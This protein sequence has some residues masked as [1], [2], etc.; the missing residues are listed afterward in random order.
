MKA[1]LRAS[2]S[3]ASSR[4]TGTRATCAR[5]SPWTRSGRERQPSRSSSSV[6]AVPRGST[7]RVPTGMKSTPS[8]PAGPAWRGPRPPQPRAG[9]VTPASFRIARPYASSPR[10]TI[11]RRM[12][13]S[14]VPRISATAYVVEIA[15]GRQLGQPAW[16]TIMA[17]WGCAPPRRV[18]CVGRS[19]I[20]RFLI[21]SLIG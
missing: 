20:V 11:A 4:A 17:R 21:R 15:K 5:R 18:V 14:N 7:S 9:V 2:G 19:G 8:A 1:G 13:C 16:D 3:P 12:A 10:R 6:A